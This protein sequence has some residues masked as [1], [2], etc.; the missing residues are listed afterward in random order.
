M[1]PRADRVK[2]VLERLDWNDRPLA[3]NLGLA[4]ESGLEITLAV[5]L[6]NQTAEMVAQKDFQPALFSQQG[7]LK[8]MGETG[9][10]FNLSIKVMQGSNPLRSLLLHQHNTWFD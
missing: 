2:G 4:I 7:G 5:R 10:P 9:C 3:T 1:L 6:L 8:L